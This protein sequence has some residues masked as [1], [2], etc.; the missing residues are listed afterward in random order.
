MMDVT[1]LNA[2]ILIADDQQPNIDVLTGLLDVKGFTNYTTTLD[3]RQVINL[4]EKFKPDLLLLDLKMP[5][6]TGFQVMAQ[7]KDLIPVNTYFPIL[8]LTADITLESKQ[9][10]LANGACD[11]LS[12][13]FDLLEVDLR[14]KNLLKTRYFY[15]QLENQNLILEEKVKE[16]TSELE[17]RNIEL[18][19]AKEQAEESDKL[20][21]EFLNQMSH[22][23]RSPLR[24]VLSTANSYRD[25]LAEQIKPDFIDYFGIDSTGHRLIRSVDLI[26]NVTEMQAGTYEPSFTEFDLVKDIIKK[27]SNDNINLIEDKGLKFNFFS[28]LSDT[29]IVGD[30][31]SIYQI[32][33]NLIDNSIRYTN[34]GYIS[35]NVS[36]DEQK[37]IVSID[38]TGIGISEE[39]LKIMYHPLMH[40]ERGN[41]GRYVGNGLG[42]SLIQ[43][44]CDLNRI[45]LTVE[46]KKDAGTK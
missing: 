40:A 43:T 18:L 17:K 19:A 32:F 1:L 5:H 44:Y 6:V 36:K 3:S 2:K 37:I 10:A 14:I 15:Q 33:V 34:K 28:A 22:E 38:D 16:R 30:Q 23:I 35:I 26:L 20:K 7:L 25:D 27:I 24:D 12:K 42:L 29:M 45:A 39:F 31:Y 9:R 13:P 41:S 46:S 4:F 21:S 8:V 11:F